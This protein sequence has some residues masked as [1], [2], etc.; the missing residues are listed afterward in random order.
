M[1]L[2]CTVCGTYSIGLKSN[3][4]LLPEPHISW[5]CIFC[6]PIQDLPAIEIQKRNLQACACCGMLTKRIP[7]C[8]TE[9]LIQKELDNVTGK[10]T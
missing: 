7:V 10:I 5:D 6:F 3:L 9:C 2:S 1:H 8:S 4:R